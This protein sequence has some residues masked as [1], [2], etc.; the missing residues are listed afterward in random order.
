MAQTEFKSYV[1]FDTTNSKWYTDKDEY[2]DELVEY[3]DIDSFERWVNEQF[4]A[5]D[6]LYQFDDDANIGETRQE[7]LKVY[8]DYVNEFIDGRIQGGDAMVFVS[9][10]Q[11]EASDIDIV[12]LIDNR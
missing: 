1:I 2:I 10:S 9:T 8:N 4:Q 3:G 7:L 6:I 11:M 5:C 12:D